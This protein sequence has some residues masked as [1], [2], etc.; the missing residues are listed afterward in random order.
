MG[1]READDWALHLVVWK[2]VEMESKMAVKS[3][4]PMTD[5]KDY[6]RVDDLVRPLAEKM[7]LLTVMRKVEVQLADLKVVEKDPFLVEELVLLRA[8]Q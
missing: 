1:K 4:V 5:V 6:M 8:K 7:D 2:A 3:V